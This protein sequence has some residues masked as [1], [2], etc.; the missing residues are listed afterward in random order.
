[1]TE[2]LSDV[3][4]FGFVVAFPPIP[5]LNSAFLSNGFVASVLKVDFTVGV[6][7]DC[8]VAFVVA[9]FIGCSDGGVLV[10]LKLLVLVDFGW[11]VAV[12]VAAEEDGN[13]DLT[14]IGGFSGFVDTIGGLTAVTIGFVFTSL[15]LLKLLKLLLPPPIMLLLPLGG[16]W[17]LSVLLTGATRATGAF[18]A[19]GR[20]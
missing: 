1:M 7:F 12:V 4:H 20:K 14:A 8:G 6:V 15:L 19:L 11:T 5:A 13:T 3:F 18:N 17:T 2:L 9:A 16:F 10:R